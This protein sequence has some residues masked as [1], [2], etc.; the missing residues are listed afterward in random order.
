MGRY[1]ALHDGEPKEVADAV[2][3]HYRPR[4]A[5]DGLPEGPVA[6]AV[7]LA[8]KLDALAGLFGVGQQP[9]G[10]KDPFALRRHALGVVRILIERNLPLSL[11]E[12]VNAGFSVFP[13]GTLGDAHTDVQMFIHERLRGYLREAGYTANE[14]ESVLCMNPARLDQVPLQ[15]AAVRAF[16]GLPEA[17]SL[18]AANKRV[19]NILKQA[20]AKGETFDKAQQPYLKEA[21]ERNLFDALQK[22]SAHAKPLFERGDYSAY[23]KS[24]AVLKSPVDAFFDAVMVMAD[25]PELRQNRLALLSELRTEMNRVADISKLA[26]EK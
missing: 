19:A 12:L 24:F 3:Q 6:L 21:A 7:A 2:E 26:V 18:A 23:L 15:L 13:H 5:G 14:I 10:D 20:E 16:M 1:Y 9:S 4:F 25:E 11:P 8:D 22:T 17:T